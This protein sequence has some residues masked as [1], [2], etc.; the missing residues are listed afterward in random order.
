MVSNN[1]NQDFK[2]I[3]LHLHLQDLTNLVEDLGKT[4][5]IN[6][7]LKEAGIRIKIRAVMVA[8]IHKVL[9]VMA[10]TIAV[11]MVVGKEVHKVV[12]MV[13]HQAVVTVHHKVED[14]EVMA[15]LLVVDMEVHKV[16]VMEDLKEVMEDLK[17][18]I[19][20]LKVEV[21]ADHKGEVTE[22]VQQ[23]K[24]RVIGDLQ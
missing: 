4:T 18:D 24:V 22:Q 13:V 2:E 5:L 6:H 10:V 20:D 14:M 23:D 21:T 12:V 11:D 8:D 16:E 3:M 17:E 9:E 1:N 15:L 7:H 19:M